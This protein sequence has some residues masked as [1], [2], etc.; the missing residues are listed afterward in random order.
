[1]RASRRNGLDSPTAL[2]PQVRQRLGRGDA[3]VGLMRLGNAED[4][5][6]ASEQIGTEHRFV[7]SQLTET[8]GLSVTDTTGSAYTSTTGRA[9]ST[10]ERAVGK[11]GPVPSIGTAAAAG[12]AVETSVSRSVRPGTPRAPARPSRSARASA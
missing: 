5:K 1:M 8:I 6:A 3:A 10:T 12:G 7:L 11:R 4:A 9:D 2:S